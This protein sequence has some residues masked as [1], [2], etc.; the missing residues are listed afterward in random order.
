MAI[1]T[2]IK[3]ALYVVLSSILAAC[4]VMDDAIVLGKEFT[5]RKNQTAALSGSDL[6]VKML[7]AGRSQRQKGGDEIFCTFDLARGE[8]HNE[9]TLNVGEATNAGDKTVK[10]T[11]VD[12]TTSPKAKDPWETNSCSFIV[13]QKQ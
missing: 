8:S 5:V 9:E 2:M 6:K 3:F 11:Q 1:T 10:L 7:R 13:T 12:L 4:A